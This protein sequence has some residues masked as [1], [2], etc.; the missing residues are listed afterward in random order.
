VGAI[1]GAFWRR[2]LHTAV[3]APC[4]PRGQ[5]GAT[6][7]RDSRTWALTCVVPGGRYSNSWQALVA[8]LQSL[9]GDVGLNERLGGRRPTRNP[10]Q[11]LVQARLIGAVRERLG[12]ADSAFFSSPLARKAL[13]RRGDHPRSAALSGAALRGSAGKD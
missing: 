3:T 2:L 1:P 7:P 13:R 11:S 5:C 4:T 8:R 10:G 9:I 6:G 12:E